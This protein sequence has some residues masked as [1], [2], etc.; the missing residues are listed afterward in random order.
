MKSKP[1]LTIECATIKIHCLKM[2]IK[3]EMGGEMKMVK[4]KFENKR[5]QILGNRRKPYDT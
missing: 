5:L 4:Y 3:L 2:K 1:K